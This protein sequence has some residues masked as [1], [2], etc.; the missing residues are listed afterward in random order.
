MHTQNSTD[1]PLTDAESRR[2]RSEYFLS[3]ARRCQERARYYYEYAVH[4][5]ALAY[6]E[7]R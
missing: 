1:Q 2:L 4:Y 7:Q 3:E 5:Q 6:H